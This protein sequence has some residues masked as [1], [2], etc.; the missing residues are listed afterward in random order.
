VVG[1]PEF[2]E[3]MDALD[4]YP[5]GDHAVDVRHVKT[6]EALDGLHVLVVGPSPPGEQA[7]QYLRVARNVR[8]RSS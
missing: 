5:G 8:K 6:L 3:A 1:E 7:D 2:L 4:G